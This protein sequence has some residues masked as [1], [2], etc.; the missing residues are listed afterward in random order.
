MNYDAIV[1]GSG[2]AGVNAA[3]PLVEAG[4]NVALVDY[5]NRDATYAPLISE[6]PFSRLRSTDAAQ[7]RYFLGDR[8]EGLPSGELRVGAQLTP[9]RQYVYA[10]VSRWMPVVSETFSAM[11]SLA[12]GGLGNA[13]GAG[14]FC[15]SSGELAEI[16]L[17][18]A[19]MRS[20]YERVAARIGVS[21]MRDDLLPFLGDSEWLMPPLQ[22]DSNAE[23]LLARYVARRRKLQAAGFYLGQTRL[24][25][26]T[27]PHAGRAAYG[28]QDMDFWADPGRSVYRPRWTLEELA[29]RPNFA[30][31]DRR[32]VLSFAE[33]ADGQVR[34]ETRHADC[35]R[36]QI[37]Q[38]GV[39]V[40][41]AG[42]LST[43]RIVLRSL[44]RYGHPVPLLCNPYTYVP[45]VNLHSLGRAA[46]D[47]R[48]SLA[49]LTAI[50]APADG[51]DLV[52]TQFYSYR[53]LLTFKLMKEVPLGGR[54]ALRALRLLMNAF[55]ILGINHADR[56]A[57]TKSCTLQPGRHDR[58]DELHIEYKP[59]P[60]EECRRIEHEKQVLRCFRRLGC[61]PVKRVA[62]G[63]GSSIHYAGTLPI[64]LTDRELTCDQE[65]RLRG[66]SNVYLADGSVFGYL[67]AKGLTL[68]I[69]AN[70]DRVG[71]VVSA[72]LASGMRRAAA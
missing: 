56:P 42:T 19:V 54:E 64:D 68:S 7:H 57:R 65:C 13:W 14:A 9:P 48:C 69:M 66:T 21:G 63:E 3:V 23:R 25:L 52:Q 45:V 71:G 12:Q 39:L 38:A 1:V 6:A 30:Y 46:R 72:R 4:W 10:D 44:R 11:E 35:D 59:T 5:G 28:Y 24:A 47:E 18:P 58:P 62:P 36:T 32:F 17:A 70:A 33:T 37:L 49:Q 27:R 60:D 20:H 2:P 51:G 55:G 15:F 40:L 41:G 8:F 53:S 16:G 61:W 29:Q 50:Y 26:C 31:L 34:I 22:L 43:T 67:P